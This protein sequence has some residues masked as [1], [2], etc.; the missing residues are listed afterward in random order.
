MTTLR[1]SDTRIPP[2]SYAQVAYR[3]EPVR[4]EHRSGPP[5]FIVSEADMRLLA[6][7]KRA[8]FDDAADVAMTRYDEL[9]SRL[10][11]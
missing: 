5:V 7:A 2:A 1:A 9:L 3:G 8:R 6:E 10:A 11:Q 4:V